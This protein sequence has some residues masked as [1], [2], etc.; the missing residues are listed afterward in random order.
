M[1]GTVVGVMVEEGGVSLMEGGG[2]SLMEGGG[3]SL[4]EEGGVSLVEGG[5]VSLVEVCVRCK[6]VYVLV[7]AVCIGFHFA[8][9]S[10]FFVSLYLCCWKS[11]FLI[12]HM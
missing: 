7:C 8:D 2:V 12:Q 3:V 6:K 1:S 11:P 9:E 4:V 5:G 10:L